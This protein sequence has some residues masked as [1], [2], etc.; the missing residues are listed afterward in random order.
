MAIPIEPVTFSL[1][2][3]GQRIK[4]PPPWSPG[5]PAWLREMG[6]TKVLVIDDQVQS[7]AELSDEDALR[8]RICEPLNVEFVFCPECAEGH[9]LARGRKW[10]DAV[11]ARIEEMKG[12]LAAVFLDIMFDGETDPHEGSGIHFL[13]RIS[14]VAQGFPV[15]IMTQARDERRLHELLAEAGLHFD[16]L[17]KDSGDRVDALCRF[18]CE[19]GWVSDP[20][21]NAF[22]QTMRDGLAGLRRYAIKRPSIDRSQFNYGFGDRDEESFD[23]PKPLLF[24]APSG[25]GKTR[26]AE[27]AAHW[28]M[29]ITPRVCTSRAIEVLD[30]NALQRDQGAKIAVFGRGP[31]DSTRR[32]QADASGLVVRGKAQKAADGILVIDE[33]GNSDQELQEMLLAFVESGRTEPEFR[34]DR[35]TAAALGPL[36]VLCIFTAQLRHIQEGRIIEDIER[37]IKRGEVVDIAPLRERPEEVVPIF[38]QTLKT[39]RRN[40]DVSWR[41][42]GDI[43]DLLPPASQA[44]LREAVAEFGLSASALADLVGEPAEA[45]KVI[46]VPYLKHRLKNRLK[47]KPPG[48]PPA[49]P[50]EAEPRPAA[51][52]TAS[53][54]QLDPIELV[55]RLA[56][57]RDLRFPRDKKDELEGYLSR[58]QAAASNLI[59]PYL[60]AC[61]DIARGAK[62]D[63]NV[64][65]TYKF[66]SG[67]HDIKKTTAATRLKELLL[68]SKDSTLNALR[69]SE[70]L[71]GLAIA[72]ADRSKE[73]QQLLDELAREP[74]QQ[75]R[76]RR[77]GWDVKGTIQHGSQNQ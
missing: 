29:Q 4:L 63:L 74:S 59:L 45:V 52:P 34:N 19:H 22:S 75:E 28:L 51:A 73:V 37:R 10:F 66:V 6:R 12:S 47:A 20:A 14:E 8:E 25:E 43:N 70:L 50:T 23:M 13:A 46:G 57:M 77:L 61:L 65:G 18:L 7:L 9:P 62:S 42:P 31:Q 53:L 24:L 56:D 49:Q 54:D 33:L 26:T 40:Q 67:E 39:Y 21:F 16:F 72:V 55:E 27:L 32:E 44:W 58:V 60:E 76:L 3:G 69:T 41:E 17:L 2:G 68:I 71:A 36:R 64:V 11:A 35:M 1:P 38:Y 5:A 15:L 48:R 30:C